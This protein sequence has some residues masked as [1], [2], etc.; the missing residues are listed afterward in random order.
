LAVPAFSVFAKSLQ[1]LYLLFRTIMINFRL[2]RLESQVVQKGKVR[3]SKV[4]GS[5]VQR[6]KIWQYERLAPFLCSLSKT[7][8]QNQAGCGSS[9]MPS[10]N[11]EP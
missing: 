10:L 9:D 1:A 8:T 11:V 2:N 7:V 5:E 3:G 4:Q 6:F